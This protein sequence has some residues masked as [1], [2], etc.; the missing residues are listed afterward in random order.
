MVQY[1]PRFSASLVLSMALIA[2]ACAKTDNNAAADSALNKDIQLANRDT[3]AQ[4]A[5]TDIPAASSTTSGASAVA[6]RTTTR[7]TTPRTTTRTPTTTTRTPTSSVTSS[8]N[9]VNR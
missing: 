3:A 1:I 7:T 2:G 8:G 5:L 6:P 4:P 9:P